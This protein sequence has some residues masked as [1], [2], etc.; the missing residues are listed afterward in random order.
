ML[1]FS[2]FGL[3]ALLVKLIPAGFFVAVFWWRGRSRR[4]MLDRFAAELGARRTGPAML[5][6]SSEGIGWR[7][8][9]VRSALRWETWEVRYPAL[10][11]PDFFIRAETKGDRRWMRWGMLVKPRVG[12]PAFDERHLVLCRHPSGALRLLGD[13]EVRRAISEL[14]FQLPGKRAGGIAWVGCGHGL[15]VRFHDQVLESKE[16]GERLRPL[17]RLAALLARQPA[18]PH[19]AGP[20]R[21]EAL[22]PVAAGERTALVL[23]ITIPL[24]EALVIPAAEILT[25]VEVRQAW[26]S[27]V[28]LGLA[29]GVV[30]G[31]GWL[32]AA[33]RTPR[34]PTSLDGALLLLGF[35]L[36]LGPAAYCVGNRALV[37]GPGEV[38]VVTV[39]ESEL[40]DCGVFKCRLLS[41]GGLDRASAPW[42][43]PLN[44]GD[45]V[46]LRSARGALGGRMLLEVRP[47]HLRTSAAAD[48]R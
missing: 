27:G 38:R 12:D 16:L 46:E 43:M 33:A 40:R 31:G 37:S 20:L 32:L 13:G 48:G 26:S 11:L 36:F 22:D 1:H 34:F 8:R 25:G 24:L 5:E 35:G 21:A 23:S 4:R 42:D 17:H 3:Q 18:Q 9:L 7:V 45:I 47:A 39:D 30:L 28:L 2:S 14:G 29:G 10:R 15:T 44:R 6:G 19:E 41:A